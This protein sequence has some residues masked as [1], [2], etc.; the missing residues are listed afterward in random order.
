[1]SSKSIA[2][3][4]SRGIPAGYGGFETFAEELGTRLAA[5]GVDVTVY[6]EKSPDGEEMPEYRGVKLVH[7]GVPSLGPLTT[8]LFDARCLWRAR[9]GYDVVYMLG[10]GASL[11]CFL[12]RLWG[13]SVWINMDG[14]EWARSKWSWPAKLWLRAMESVATWV[15]SLLVADAE[16]IKTHLQTRHRRQDDIAVI[17]YGAHVVDEMP[18]SE[19]LHDC[20]VRSEEYYLVVCRL[21]P[22]NHIEEIVD[23]YRAAGSA[24]PL[25]VVGDID[26]ASPFAARLREIRDERVRFVGT[27]FDQQKLS[28]LRWHCR[29]YLHG[30]SVGGTNP[31]LLEAL[32]CGNRVIAHDNM[33]NREVAADCAEYFSKSTDI[34][35]II[36][37]TDAAPPRIDERES[38]QDRIRSVYSWPGIA[39]AYS[40]LL[41]N[42][43]G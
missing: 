16:G 37:K 26:A 22:E 27:I 6:C 21:E 31:S 28:A 43:G 9:K 4:G 33:F 41:A 35:A 39:R 38:A 40:R 42:D 8:I 29:A 19:L 25:I 5:E 32:G 24:F 3:L 10:Y 23:G 14:I 15:A 20:G 18:P 17:A 13:A 12:P 7:L 30:H 11:F 34:P 2:I 36:G 1:M